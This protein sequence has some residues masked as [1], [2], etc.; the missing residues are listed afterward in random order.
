[1]ARLIVA[2]HDG[3]AL[4]LYD[5]TDV[6]EEILERVLPFLQENEK[7]HYETATKVGYDVAQRFIYAVTAQTSQRTYTLL[8]VLGF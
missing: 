4:Q 7:K 1:M 3:Q 6:T 8:S 2:G 5:V